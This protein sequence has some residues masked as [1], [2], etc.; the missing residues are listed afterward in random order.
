MTDQRDEA[1]TRI[2]GLEKATG[3][4]IAE[5]QAIVR[6]LG[7]DKHGEIIAA[8][9]AQHGLT[10]GY[11]N[12]LALLHRGWGTAVADDL[13]SGLFAGPKVALRP[14]YERL[15]E[16]VTAFGPDVE[17]APKQTMVMFRRSKGF[18]CFTPSSGKRAEVGI[19]LRGDPP[20]DRL[21]ASKGMT[22]HAVWIEDAAALDDEVIGWLR[23]AYD[24][25]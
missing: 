13:V 20:T 9:K 15:V 1:A 3:K 23:A 16:L 6:G 25:S 5:W 11:A 17:I 21:R 18:A 7:T 22:S 10:H 8:L 14:I 19:A 12:L 4:P 2:A 24:R